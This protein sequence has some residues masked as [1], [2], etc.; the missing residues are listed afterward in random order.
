MLVVVGSWV[1]TTNQKH[2]NL[3]QGDGEDA[4]EE[5][6]G[7]EEEEEDGDEADGVGLDG[8]ELHALSGKR[9]DM[10]VNE[11]LDTI[12]ERGKVGVVW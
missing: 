9:K 2:T 12:R 3:L 10:A 4:E 1:P 11:A 6:G 7:G 8:E 5:E